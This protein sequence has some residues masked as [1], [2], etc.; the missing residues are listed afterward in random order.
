[1][2]QEQN[3]YLKYRGKCKEMSEALIEQNPKLK[4]IRGHYHYLNGGHIDQHWWCVDEDGKIIDPTCRQFPCK[5]LGEY[6][7]FN[8]VIT[9]SQCGIKVKEERAT[10]YSN[11]AYCSYECNGKHIGVL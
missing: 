2:N 10:F 6:I 5:G 1:M 7:E 11:Y 3:D 9:C 8:G 4:L